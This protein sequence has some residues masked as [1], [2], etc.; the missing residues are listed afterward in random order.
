MFEKPLREVMRSKVEAFAK[1]TCTE[2]SSCV[3]L[4]CDHGG[5]P[6]LYCH[7]PVCLFIIF[8]ICDLGS[9]AGSHYLSS[10][11]K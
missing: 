10:P 6:R 4:P 7:D 9:V 5:G 2:R 3:Y 1:Q 11:A 8:L